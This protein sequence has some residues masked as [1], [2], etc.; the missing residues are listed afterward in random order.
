VE[1]LVIALW[2][3]SGTT[4]PEI[5]AALLADWAPNAL[6]T[7]AIQALTVHTQLADQ[8]P[9]THVPDARGD[10]PNADALIVLGLESAHDLDS[11]PER[12][13]LHALARRIEVWRVHTHA[14]LR[15]DPD[16]SLPEVTMVSFVPRRADLSHEQFVRHWTERHTPLALRHH[17]GLCGYRQHVV[18]RAFT[19]G[20]RDFDGVAELDFATRSDFAERFY[21]DA[22]GKAVIRE[23]VARFIEPM[24]V[25]LTTLMDTTILRSSGSETP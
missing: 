12:D 20:G 2:R 15:G 11:V 21:D 1:T 3:A 7:D 16:G 25:R 23:D 17:V 8:G 18:R 22:A 5:R 19:P 9:H 6:G 10:V 14:Q 13:A 4:A 24:P